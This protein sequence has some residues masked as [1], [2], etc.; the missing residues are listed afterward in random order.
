M[1]SKRNSDSSLM[2]PQW[3]NMPTIASPQPIDEGVQVNTHT[4]HP[5]RDSR[6]SYFD[7]KLM[8]Q[9]A[10]MLDVPRATTL[11]SKL[12][13]G[14]APMLSVEQLKDIIDKTPQ[15]RLMLLDIRSTQS[16]S[17]SRIQ[18]AMNLCIP[19]TLL[20]RATFNIEKLQQTFQS[21][22]DSGKFA[23]WKDMDWIIVYDAHSSDPRD[24][25]TAQNMI[26]KFTSAGFI[27]NTAIL[28]GG[29]AHFR[30]S[31][32]RLIDEK[33]TQSPGGS[34]R[35]V[36][37][38]PGPG[39]LAPVIG[40]V[41]LPTTMN[42]ANPFFS[43]IRQ[44]MDL[45][46]GVGQ[47][48]V[49]RPDNLEDDSLPAWLRDAAAVEDHGKKV[50]EKFL[51]IEREE[52]SRMSGAYAAF[53]P[54]NEGK[55][56]VQLCGVEKGVKNR[57]KDI[58]PFEHARVRL[59]SKPEGCCDY[60]N[61]SHIS[62]SRTNKKYIATQG[63]L[64]ATFEDFWSVVW[65]QDVRVI[66]MLTATSEGGQ[67]KCH[68]YWEQHDY[69][70]MRLQ[71]LSEKKASLDMDRHRS[72]STT[73]PMTSSSERSRR[74]AATTNAF[75]SAANGPAKNERPY[76]IIRK[77]ALSHAAHPFAAMREVTQLH[78]PSWPDFGTPA[79]PSHLLAL[80]ELAN[81]TQRAAMPVETNNVSRGSTMDALPVSWH[82]EPEMDSDSRP[83]MVH[84]SAGC[85]R[86]GAFCTVDSVIDMLKRKRQANAS[87]N[88][89][90][91]GDV[92]MTDAN[93]DISPFAVGAK[94][95]P[96]SY[97]QPDIRSTVNKVSMDLPKTQDGE[98][99]VDTRF[100]QDDTVDL[101]QKTVEDFRQQRL[102]M[103][104]SLRQYVL[105]YETVLEW[106]NRVQGRG[107]NGPPD[108]RKRSEST[109]AQ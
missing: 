19:T 11:P 51:N 99:S 102:S 45:A 70:D 14:E 82:D 30:S 1:E 78:F 84:C 80:V 95:A 57:Y 20:K 58:L 91:Q 92:A 41:N 55:N 56:S 79:E 3:Q 40:G 32:P 29:F 16:Y 75:E 71:P 74:R 42:S 35:P 13:A 25:V 105:C 28:R 5:E 97:F 101:V 49:G 72:D 109:T 6:L 64:P 87:L 96:D 34:S 12:L 53:N 86:T 46:D 73:S 48:D 37:S 22:P 2:P 47:L 10:G 88:A 62:A 54:N 24:A 23:N 7:P 66:I 68:P 90:S 85:G 63:P 98:T 83:M 26:K 38:K 67:L 43:N 81:L 89:D 108:G 44:N 50:S 9:S 104:Q 61:A 107:P 77:F 39:G 18:N 103:V 93:E 17:Q 33:S 65:D 100:L 21:G 94:A 31:Y 59:G 60:V 15:D 4:K 36:L 52:Q 8:P 69:G 27:K 106:V 76:V